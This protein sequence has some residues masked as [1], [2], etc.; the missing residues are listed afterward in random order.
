MAG[1]VVV[2]SVLIAP[3]WCVLTAKKYGHD[4]ATCFKLIC[5]SPQWAESGD[6]GH[7]R[8]AGSGCGGP[9]RATISTV[10]GSTEPSSSGSSSSSTLFSPHQRK[11]LAGMF[12]N[13]KI[14]E[15]RLTGTFNSHSWILDIS[16]KHHVTG[17]ITWL[18]TVHD[19]ADR[20]VGLPNGIIVIANKEGSVH[21]FSTIILTHVLY[22]P[23]LYCN[24]LS[25]S[26]L[27]DGLHCIV[28]YDSV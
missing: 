24:L 15:N 21:L 8:T 27:Y 10:G 22:V 3:P 26:Q 4:V 7:G 19:I 13:V 16:A 1:V 9:S 12:G 18:F 17:D 11:A 20:P 5:Y 23:Q 6:H 28:Q 25:I 2:V 14:L